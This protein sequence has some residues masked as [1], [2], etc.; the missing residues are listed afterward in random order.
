[1]SE[2]D[3]LGGPDTVFKL[4]AFPKDYEWNG[5]SSADI[6]A[7]KMAD[8]FC[9]VL[10]A[11]VNYM[12]LARLYINGVFQG[13]YGFIE[14]VNAD[15]IARRWPYTPLGNPGMQISLHGCVRAYN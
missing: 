11:P 10:G 6:M 8:D 12:S 4:K 5:G 2:T 14:K 13:L 15:F 1:M 9:T 3:N 7:E